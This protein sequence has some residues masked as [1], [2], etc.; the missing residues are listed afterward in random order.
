MPDGKLCIMIFFLHSS[1]PPPPSL[2]DRSIYN[3]RDRFALIENVVA[4]QRIWLYLSVNRVAY[5]PLCHIIPTTYYIVCK[6]VRVRYSVFSPLISTQTLQSSDEILGVYFHLWTELIFLSLFF[7]Y[8]SPSFSL[9]LPRRCLSHFCYSSLYAR[10]VCDF[11]YLSWAFSYG[12]HKKNIC[13][14]QEEK[15]THIHLI[16]VWCYRIYSIEK[17]H[18]NRCCKYVYFW[19]KDEKK[20]NSN[21]RELKHIFFFEIEFL[22]FFF[23]Y[24]Y[25]GII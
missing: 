7:L 22:I 16:A 18:C 14:S 10:T 12:E 25:V 20:T 24:H 1:P 11:I 23:F 21:R 17:T 6:S 8:L 4:N 3:F 13:V 2:H 5:G 9:S 19:M 15:N